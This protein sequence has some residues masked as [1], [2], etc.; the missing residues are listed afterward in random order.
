[1]HAPVEVTH[2]LTSVTLKWEHPDSDGSSDVTN[3]IV[4]HRA[5]YDSAYR[6]VFSSMTKSAK[7]EGLRTGF[8]H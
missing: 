4:F 7:I 5:D 2:D 3:Y 6:E 1:M 8:Y